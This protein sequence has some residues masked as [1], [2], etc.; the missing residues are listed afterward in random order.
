MFFI[1]DV[2]GKI[3]RYV[4]LLETIPVG[5]R[6]IQIGDMGLGFP[7]TTLPLVSPA[8]K[9]FRGNHDSPIKCK[10][11]PNYLGDYGYLEQ[12]DLFYLAGA[13]SIDWQW[14]VAG[15]SWWVDE[16]LSII[17]LNK[18]QQLYLEKKPRIVV[19]HDCPTIAVYEMLKE[20]LIGP[21]PAAQSTRTQQALQQMFE[22]HQPEH[23]AFGHWHRD[24][25]F[26]IGKTTFHCLNELS[27]IS[28]LTCPRSSIR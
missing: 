1:G 2:H 12:D 27:M 16:E 18:A 4:K 21:G 22:L 3:G 5:Q 13:W 6:S 23:W 7:D 14:R 11:H 17:E 10:Q 24:K 19:T 25:E 9:F 26:T 15:K 28:I 20:L 8:H